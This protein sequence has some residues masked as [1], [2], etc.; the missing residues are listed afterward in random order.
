VRIA[1]L[2]TADPLYLPAFFE[3]VFSERAEETVAV[4]VVPPL[5]KGQSTLGAAQRYFR[6]FGAGATISLTART[7]A[8]KV[9]GQSI[10][11]VCKRHGIPSATVPDVNA[12][13][14][15]ERLG[16]EGADVVISVSCPQIFKPPLIELPS[17][18]CL[19]IHGA[20]LPNYRGIMPSFWM[21]ANGERR[22]GVSIYYVN[23]AIDAGDLCG[24]ETFEVVPDETLDQFLRR[25]KA[26]AAE[27]LVR[28]LRDVEAGTVT[29][30]PLDLS[31]GSYYSWP[32]RPAVARFRAAGRSLW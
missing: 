18:G 30:T 10:A 4:Y 3:R 20:I 21:L 27:L 8:A 19:N 2:T 5:Y 23:E 28:V 17:R 1:F 29:R 6:T 11:A 24:Q 22:A 32:D 26:V 9:R 15:L 31:Q 25:S 14:F 12:P 13:E 16:R 7:L